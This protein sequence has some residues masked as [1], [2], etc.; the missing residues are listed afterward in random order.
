MP[1]QVRIL[2]LP[3]RSERCWA[4]TTRLSHPELSRFVTTRAKLYAAVF[5][6]SGCECT[7]VAIVN[8]FDA[9]PSHAEITA[10]GMS[11]RCLSVPHV[12]RASR[13]RRWRTPAA[14][15]I[16]AHGDV[17]ACVRRHHSSLE[18][19]CNQGLVLLGGCRNPLGHFVDAL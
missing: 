4:L 15:S 16:R 1:T 11:R 14:F 12:C 5:N 8:A 7:Y 17:N 10:I 2:D 6:A 18:P 3:P 9:W 19:T 13:N